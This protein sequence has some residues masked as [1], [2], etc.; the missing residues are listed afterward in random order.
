MMINRE[1]ISVTFDASDVL[2]VNGDVVTVAVPEA[3]VLNG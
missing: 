3:T 1:E 2:F